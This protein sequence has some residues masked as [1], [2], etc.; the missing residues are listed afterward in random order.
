MT[1]LSSG[2]SIRILSQDGNFLGTDHIDTFKFADGTVW[3]WP[4]A[5]AIFDAQAVSAG[6]DYAGGFNDQLDDFTGGP[7]DDYFYGGSGGDTFRFNAGDGHDVIGH[8]GINDQGGFNRIVFGE[9]ILPEKVLITRPS[10]ND[11]LLTMNE[12]RD[13]L[14][15]IAQDGNF[16]NIDHID[17]FVFSE[18]TV[19]SWGDVLAIYNQQAVSA[20]D[21]YVVGFSGARD[22]LRGGLGNDTLI[23]GTGGDDYYFD[24]GDGHDVISHVGINDIGGNNV[25]HLGE[26][27]LPEGCW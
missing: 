9:G 17:E 21:D 25:L 27:I 24:L 23:G 15:I 7:G 5:L 10:S 2:D 1:V 12:G 13:S 3:S 22:S 11:L 18:G 19:W 4:D 14:R 20:G 26:G 6:H 16:Q 8:N